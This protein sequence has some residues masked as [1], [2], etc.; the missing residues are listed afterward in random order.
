MSATLNHTLHFQLLAKRS[1]FTVQTFPNGILAGF[2]HSPMIGIR[3]FSGGGRFGAET[4]SSAELQVTVKTSSLAV[5]DD[6]KEKDRREIERIMRDEV[7][8]T[9]AFPEVH[10]QSTNITVN[11][12]VP[13]RYKAHIIGDLTLHGVKRNGLW[14]LAQLTVDGDT[15]RAQ[16]DFTLRQ[17]DYGIKLVSIAAGA[18]RL[19]DELKFVFDLVG[20]F[21]DE[22]SG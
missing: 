4:L 16:G 19:K 2:G 9:S 8:V 20:K 15:L 18:L 6:I 10:F 21:I 3:D 5:L 13:G 22:G 11:R 14:I 12:I 1:T 7:L 17:T